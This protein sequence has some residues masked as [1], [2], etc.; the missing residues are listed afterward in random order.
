VKTVEYVG[1]Y[2][3][4]MA[5]TDDGGPVWVLTHYVRG[6][7]DPHAIVDVPATW[8]F[9]DRPGGRGYRVQEWTLSR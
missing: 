3:V 4:E 5:I 7:L 2:S 9:I 6:D 8:S 1:E